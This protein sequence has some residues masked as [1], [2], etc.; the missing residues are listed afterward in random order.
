M[1]V[2]KFTQFIL[3][4]NRHAIFVAI[5]CGVLPLLGWVSAVIVALV[6]L[7]KSVTDGFIVLLW[8]SLPYVVIAS[9]NRSGWLL[10]HAI[11]FGSLFV[12]LLAILLRRSANFVLT[13]ESA[14][15][16]GVVA[17]LIFHGVVSDPHVWWT[18]YIVD[19]AS[20]LTSVAHVNLDMG[21]VKRTA[22]LVAPYMTGIQS[23]II[24][25]GVILQIIIARSLQ[26]NLFDAWLW[27][28]EWRVFRLN[29]SMVVLLAL[30]SILFWIRPALF[31]DLLPVLVLPLLF[32]GVSLVHTCMAMVKLSSAIVWLFYLLIIVILLAMPMLL[33]VLMIIAI[34]DSFLDFRTKI[35]RYIDR[36]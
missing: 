12:W 14:V 28:R 11:L 26:A 3:Q 24:V 5:L 19:N 8:A 36:S 23:V 6:T 33:G 4:S 7:C 21:W 34:M 17:V 10:V 1:L 9:V 35:L 2:K 32:A 20:K 13:V 29:Q 30:F 18:K 27:L 25:F 15:V 31:R 22:Q 16:V